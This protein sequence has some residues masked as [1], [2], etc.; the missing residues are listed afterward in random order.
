MT[1]KYDAILSS[2]EKLGCI[3]N[4]VHYP[5]WKELDCENEIKQAL[6][7]AKRY[8]QLKPIL[9]G[10]LE[11]GDKATQGLWTTTTIDGSDFVE[12][13]TQLHPVCSN[14]DFYPTAV[15]VED[16]QFFVTAANVINEI[17]EIENDK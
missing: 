14:E 1:N 2:I 4:A 16:Q 5:T 17:R 8:Q 3:A 6:E 11:A 7:D 10:F 12:T 9:D 13:D 15:E